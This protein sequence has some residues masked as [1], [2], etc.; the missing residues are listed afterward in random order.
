MAVGSCRHCGYSPIAPDASFCPKCG[1]IDPYAL[2][3]TARVWKLAVGLVLMLGGALLILGEVVLSLRHVLFGGT[4]CVGFLGAIVM[5]C[6]VGLLIDIARNRGR[7][8]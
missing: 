7:W 8:N 4:A 6:G 1:S 5:L 3:G 2:T